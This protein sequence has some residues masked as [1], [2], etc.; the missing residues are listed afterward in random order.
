MYGGVSLTQVSEKLHS[1]L[2][3]PTQYSNWVTNVVLVPKS[4]MKWRMCVDYIDLNKATPNDSFPM[5]QIDQLVDA[6]TGNT[7]LSFLDAYYGYH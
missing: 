4:N 2:L 5:P 7:M 3:R 6:T 1:G